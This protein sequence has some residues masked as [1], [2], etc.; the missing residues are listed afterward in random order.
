MC[1]ADQV[2]E[3]TASDYKCMRT[4]EGA[5][6]LIDISVET[7][8]RDQMARMLTDGRGIKYCSSTIHLIKN[9]VHSEYASLI[10]NSV[11]YSR[12][13]KRLLRTILHIEEEN[14]MVVIV[15]IF[16]PDETV[17]LDKPKL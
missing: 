2:N 17:V 3:D 16:E 15:A 11:A 10:K 12:G 1:G 13:L 8:T 5:M 7:C 6:E 9:E 14:Y 4:V